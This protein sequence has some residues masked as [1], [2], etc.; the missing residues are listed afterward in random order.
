MATRGRLWY[1]D[2]LR[3]AMIVLVIFH[4]TAVTYGGAGSWYYSEAQTA[5]P[6]RVLL[7]M[8]T[9][10]NQAF[11]M[12]LLFFLSG[13]FTVPSHLRKGPGPYLR[14]RLIR[15]G[16]P[17]VVY[18]WAIE[19][20]VAFML[21]GAPRLGFAGFYVHNLAAPDL[22]PMW[23]VEALLI[24]DVIF[25]AVAAAWP[26]VLRAREAAFPGPG[27]L[28][29]FAVGLGLFAFC[30]RLVLPAA[31]HQLL[32]LQLGYFP[33]YVAMFALGV[34]AER[35]GWLRGA[36]PWAAEHR[37]RGFIWAAL[38]FE[39]PLLIV[40]TAGRPDV[41]AFYGGWHWQ[42]LGYALWE[43]FVCVGMGV[44]LLAAGRRRL[45]RPGPVWRFL[46]D[47]SYT[48]YIIH[49]LVLVGVALAWRGVAAEALVKFLVTGTVATAVAFGLAW[50]IRRVKATRV[51]LG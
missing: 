51:V 1:L 29:G 14:D 36:I 35:Q 42:A 40:G 21:Q 50:A 6:P 16:I 41:T 26:R 24:F 9:G 48:A 37:A 33:Q 31:T 12:G 28:L 44:W 30:V 25:V 13:Y 45:D 3:A 7:T 4:H 46:S 23:F 10:W 5:L 47:Q 17:L 49:P 8:F 38:A 32:Q 15:F 27:K 11:F 18:V 39:L 22:G 43:P 19:P 34:A 2:H 20:V